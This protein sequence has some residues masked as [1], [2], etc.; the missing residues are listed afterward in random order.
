MA[1]SQRSNI[2]LGLAQLPETDDPKI[3]AE[4]SKL[5][6]AVRS[7]ASYI[8]AAT[9][10]AYVPVAEYPTITNIQGLIGT[11]LFR[12][13]KQFT[14]TTAFGQMVGMSGNDS[15]QL[16]VASALPGVP[17]IGYCSEPGGVTAGNWGQVTC[18]GIYRLSGAVAGQRY[19]L[20]TTAGSV[21][22]SL[23]GAGNLRQQISIGMN[24]T[25]TLFI[26]S[27]MN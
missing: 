22:T 13:Y 18:F 15:V 11:N 23:P 7:L 27:L 20:S 19:Y 26:P 25:D 8:E 12:V 17:A 21:Q 1:T 5:Y 24:T 9:G 16:A 10:T 2:N 6:N 3:F 4:V 14:V